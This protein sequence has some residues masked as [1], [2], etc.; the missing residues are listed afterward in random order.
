MDDGCI[1]VPM[2]QTIVDEYG[3]GASPI[4]F[5]NVD[6]SQY[7]GYWVSTASVPQGL[8]HLGLMCSF[9]AQVFRRL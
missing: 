5:D 4:P 8:I 7:Y 6:N 1:N 2:M 3:D 9:M